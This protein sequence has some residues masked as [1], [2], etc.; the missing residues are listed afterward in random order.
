[1]ADTNQIVMGHFEGDNA[2][3]Y[4][5][6]G[7]KPDYFAAVV[8]SST[9]PLRYEWWG[10][11]EDEEATALSEGI[12]VDILGV[13]T[14][15]NAS[16]NSGGI[17]AYDSE[18]GGPTITRWSSGAT[19]VAK[20]ATAHGSYIKPS[21]SSAMDKEAVFEVL[22]NTTLHTSEPTWPSAIGERVTDGASVVLERVNV[23]TTRVG[24]Q[25]VRIAAT[26]VPD[27]EECYYTAIQADKVIDHGDV[28]GWSSGVYGA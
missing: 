26:L 14:Y 23:A 25:G 22:A 3:I 15:L 1:M 24:Y 16:S 17:A 19:V 28:D 7:F 21:A 6:I 9:S 20:T 13:P 18:S 2:L 5:P 10:R 11:M 8:M 27:G 12:T 4:L